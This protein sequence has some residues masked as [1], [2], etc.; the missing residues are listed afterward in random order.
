MYSEVILASTLTDVTS[1]A[2]NRKEDTKVVIQVSGFDDKVN[3]LGLVIETIEPPPRDLFISSFQAH[4]GGGG[5]I[6]KGDL[7]D[8]EGLI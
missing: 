8:R 2:W 6:E 5:L 4:L 3:V 1:L 7:F